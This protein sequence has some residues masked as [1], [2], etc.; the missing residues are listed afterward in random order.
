MLVAGG[1]HRFL[2]ERGWKFVTGTE[3]GAGRR[4][5]LTTG[6]KLM[7]VGA[8][9]QSPPHDDDY[10]QGYLTGLIRG[11]GMIGEFSYPSRSGK[12]GK[13]QAQFRLALCDTEALDRAQLW[14]AGLEVETRRF[15]HSAGQ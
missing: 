12:G 2:T 3:Q 1:D 5:H 6:N 10:R 8:L 4:P 15:V 13:N 9:P 14:L 7:G 11:D